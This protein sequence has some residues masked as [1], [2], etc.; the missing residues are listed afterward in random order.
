LLKGLTLKIHST[1]YL[2]TGAAAS[3]EG[4]TA[5][6]PEYRWRRY[7]RRIYSTAYLN[8]GGAGAPEGSTALPN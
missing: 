4:S 1:A 2:N 3:P 5:L 8:T 6:L 7:T